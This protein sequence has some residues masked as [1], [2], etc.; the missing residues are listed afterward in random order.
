M[1]QSKRFGILSKRLTELRQH[2]LPKQFSPTGSYS[3]REEDRARGYRLLI[4]AEIESY[5]EDISRTLVTDRIRAWK[6]TNTPSNLLIAF[7]ACYHSGWIELDDDHN[8]NIIS[9]ARGRSK[10]K[11]SVDEII[12]LAQ[13]QFIK[14]LK[15]NH[16]VREKNLRSLIL[17]TGLDLTQL[18]ST[19]ITNLDDF[20]KLRGEIAHQTVGVTTAINPQDEY[21]RVV[22]LLQGIKDL[23]QKLLNIS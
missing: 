5:L 9:L 17:P 19:W 6:K 7:I 16:G 2:M 1:P 23:D 3:K 11:D 21:K 22:D 8:L 10:S 12:D 18:N 13:T 15:Q 14:V 4:H 20:G